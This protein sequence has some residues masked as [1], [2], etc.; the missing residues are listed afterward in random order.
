MGAAKRTKRN[1]TKGALVKGVSKPLPIELLSEQT[2]RS[3]LQ[4]L[5]KGYSGLYALY[6]GKQLYYVGLASNIFSRL[7]SHTKNKH[8]GK[9]NRFAIYR[10]VRVRYMKDIEALVLRIAKPPGNAVG[11]NFHPDA[12]VTK[13][14]KKIQRQ[15]SRTL[16]HIRKTLREQA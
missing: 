13:V 3:E 11:G 2:F 10:I 15:Q 7:D 1:S 4:A 12:D 5:M 8:K 6:H 16:N 14:L 9:W